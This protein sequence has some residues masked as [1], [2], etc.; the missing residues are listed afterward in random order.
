MLIWGWD[1]WERESI[2]F[3]RRQPHSKINQWKVPYRMNVSFPLL[4]FLNFW[5]ITR[6]FEFTTQYIQGQIQDSRKR[7]HQQRD[8]DT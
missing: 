7:G 3:T 5:K 2:E 8:D 6:R 1:F 4:P